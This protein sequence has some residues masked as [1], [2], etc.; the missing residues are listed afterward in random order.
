MGLSSK[1]QTRI[2][3]LG[4]IT[5]TLCVFMIGPSDFILRIL[6]EESI[7][8]RIEENY[9][10]EIKKMIDLEVNKALIKEREEVQLEKQ[11]VIEAN[12]REWIRS[13]ERK[14]IRTDSRYRL[15]FRAKKGQIVKIR[16][17]V[18]SYEEIYNMPIYIRS[19]SAP[20]IVILRKYGYLHFTPEKSQIYSIEIGRTQD[21][22]V[23]SVTVDLDIY[24][25]TKVL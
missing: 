14:L 11:K 1:L 6:T 13:G 25:V 20:G 2:L 7:Q 10:S 18:K 5:F 9:Q 3:Y 12:K 15:L 24:D 4:V 8:K 19:S 21:I 16:S 17:T 22:E 23:E